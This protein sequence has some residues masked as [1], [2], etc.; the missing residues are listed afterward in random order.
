MSD[1]N[2][3]RTR[4]P[5]A[6]G[7]NLLLATALLAAS[8]A[9]ARPAGAQSAGDTAAPLPLYVDPQIAGDD[10]EPYRRSVEAELKRPVM[11]VDAPPPGDGLAVRASGA[12]QATVSFKKGAQQTERAL[13]LPRAHGKAVEAVAWMAGNVARDESAELLASLAPSPAPEAA[14]ATTDAATTTAAATAATATSSAPATASKANPRGAAATRSAGEARAAAARPAPP[15]PCAADGDAGGVGFDL[16]PRVGTSTFEGLRGTHFLDIGAVGSVGGALRGLSLGGIFTVRRG[17]A[18]GAQIGGLFSGS[19]DFDGVQLAGLLALARGKVE[20]AQIGTIAA[21]G[22]LKGMQVAMV[23]VA[24]GPV[25][26]VQAG[27]INIAGPTDGVQAGMV[28]LSRGPARG[29]QLGLANVSGGATGVSLGMANIGAGDGGGLAMGLLNVGAQHDGLQFGLVNVATGKAGVQV[30]LVNYAEDSD[31]SVG[32]LTFLRRGKSYVNARV[33][34]A[35]TVG[36]AW[37][38]GGRWVHG[39]LGI[40][41]NGAGGDARFGGWLG[42]GATIPA[43]ARVWVA[44]DVSAYGMPV[45]QQGHRQQIFELAVPV[46]LKVLDSLS[47]YVGPSY[48]VSM[49]EGGVGIPAGPLTRDIESS[50]D[51]RFAHGVGLVG[52]VRGF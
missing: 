4:A 24:A 15:R 27:M 46:G 43:S 3:T 52:G 26:G 41:A 18:C 6:R 7:A 9:S 32:P 16:A 14:A 50:G 29:V 51:I 34:E 2:R 30:G 5:A 42:V 28:N 39:M 17:P 49:A 1:R 37:Q 11:L 10:A 48:R 23:G 35:G 13:P 19:G 21:S 33:S 20:G 40:A 44:P 36:V 8:L 45:A 22:A 25:E 38:H 47:V 31:A 12:H